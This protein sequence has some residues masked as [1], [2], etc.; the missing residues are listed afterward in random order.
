MVGAPGAGFGAGWGYGWGGWSSA[1]TMV[2]SYKNGTLFIAAFDTA[3]QQGIW[4]AAAEITAIKSQAQAYK[5]VD[6]ALNKISQKWRSL[7]K[8]GR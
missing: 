1:T 3:T 6:K 4:R 5:K 8:S 7:H 2:T